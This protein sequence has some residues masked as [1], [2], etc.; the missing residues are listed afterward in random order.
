MDVFPPRDQLNPT[1]QR[2]LVLG[3]SVGIS[4]GNRMYWAQRY[5]DSVV[6]QRA[7]GDCSILDGIV[8]VHSMGGWD[9]GNG[10]CARNWVKDVEELHPDVTMIVIGGAYF[11]KVKADGRWRSVCERGW[12]DPFVKRLGELLV[13]MAPNAGRRVVVL[14]AYPVGKWQKKGLDDMVDCFDRMLREAAEASGSEVL[15]L[16]GWLC[17]AHKCTMTSNDAP[18]RPDGLHFDGLGAEETARWVFEQIR[19]SR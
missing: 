13:A 2:V 17:P 18:V 8:P 11:S 7:I 12:H 14:A 15:D 5:M 16:N 9:H 3:D 19:T 4:L 6:V 10:N 1:T